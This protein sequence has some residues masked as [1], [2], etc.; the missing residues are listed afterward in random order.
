MAYRKKIENWLETDRKHWGSSVEFYM[1][2]AD[3]ANFVWH[4]EHQNTVYDITYSDLGHITLSA[5]P[6]KYWPGSFIRDIYHG[7]N[8]EASYRTMIGLLADNFVDI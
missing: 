8:S 2:D 4:I 6:S 7:D 5:L 1:I 3:C